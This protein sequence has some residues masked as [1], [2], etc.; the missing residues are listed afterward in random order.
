MWVPIFPVYPAIVSTG[1]F[2]ISFN[3]I[4][5]FSFACSFND[6]SKLPIV[7]YYFDVIS[8]NGLRTATL[9]V[10]IFSETNL[11]ASLIDSSRFFG[12]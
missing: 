6:S 12:N 10:E 1:K 9:A 7:T 4:T 11:R 8:H 3:E 5:A 2:G